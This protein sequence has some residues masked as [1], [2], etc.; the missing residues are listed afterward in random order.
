MTYNENDLGPSPTHLQWRSGKISEWTPLQALEAVALLCNRPALPKGERTW[1]ELR[2]AADAPTSLSKLLKKTSVYKCLCVHSSLAPKLLCFPP[3]LCPAAD[4]MRKAGYNPKS[5]AEWK[6]HD[7]ICLHS[8]S[9]ELLG[10]FI[11]VHVN[12]R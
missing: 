8:D 11:F 3:F 6:G 2:V 4:K 5:S 1:V 7:I 12:R 9:V 10:V